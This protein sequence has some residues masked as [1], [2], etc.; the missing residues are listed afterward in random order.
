[1]Q[2]VTSDGD[3]LTELGEQLPVS[4]LSALGLFLAAT[5]GLRIAA[6]NLSSQVILESAFPL[7]A[8]TAVVLADRHLVATGVGIRDRLSVFAYGLGGFLA[9]ALVTALHLHVLALHGTGVAT[10]LYLTLMSGTVGVAAGTV[11]GMY[12]IRQRAAVREAKRQ[13][14]RLETFAS[15]VSHD[16]RNPLMVARGRLEETF[17]TGDPEHLGAVDQSLQRMD[18]LIDDSLSIARNGAQVDDPEPVQ[19]ADLVSEAWSVVETDDAR[20]EL[21]SSKTI[22]VDAQRTKRLFENLFRNAVEHSSADVTVR[23]GSLRNG[24]YVEDDGPGIPPEKRDAVLEQG[25]SSNPDG[26]GLGLAIVRAVADAH[27]WEVIVTE[28]ADGGARF[29]FTGVRTGARF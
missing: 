22:H 20:Y 21:E 3:W 28:S 19:L 7:V 4:P 23:L 9:A 8:A 13:S 1:M 17:R 16:L 24:F 2:R 11:A 29:E 15:I 12:E 26:S 10:P 14:E 6:E 27:G 5:I 25:V 18:E